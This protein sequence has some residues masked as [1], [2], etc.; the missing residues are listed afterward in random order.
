[1]IDTDRDRHL[2]LAEASTYL[3]ISIPNSNTSS[4]R[5]LEMPKWFSDMDANGDGKISP[6]EFDSDLY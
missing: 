5:S 6:S 4:S 3:N 2:S 1:M